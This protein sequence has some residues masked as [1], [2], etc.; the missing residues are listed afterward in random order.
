MVDSTVAA[1]IRRIRAQAQEKYLSDAE[2]HARV[3]GAVAVVFH[4]DAEAPRYRGYVR[5]AV[6]IALFIDSAQNASSAP[7]PKELE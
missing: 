4:G 2:F 3:E 5:R 1:D 7:T 6:A